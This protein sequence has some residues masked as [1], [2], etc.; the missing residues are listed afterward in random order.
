MRRIGIAGGVSLY[1][2]DD[3]YLSYFNSPFIGHRRFSS[4]DVY[5]ADGIWDGPAFSPIDGRITAIRTLKMGMKRAFPTSP[6]DYAI[7][8][9]PEGVEDSVVRILHCKPRVS[10][11]DVVSKGDVIGNMVR[12]RYFC[13]WTGPHYHV[14]AMHPKDFIRPSQS[15]PIEIDTGKIGTISG[16]STNQVECKVMKCTPD[17]VMCGSREIPSANMND[18]LGHLAMAN[19]SSGI[20]DAGIPHYKQGGLLGDMFRE[21]D[22]PVHAF[23]VSVGSVSSVSDS[24]VQFTMEKN[25]F[26]TLDGEKIGGVST[27][28]YS[29]KQLIYGRPPIFLIPEARHQFEGKISEGDCVVLSINTF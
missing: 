15:F 18:Y 21:I 19:D 12:S 29:K 7:A 16:V 13:F 3:S 27:H 1:A 4:I 11:G 8:I 2:H 23:G 20:I 17:I 14:E 25:V 9:A 28:L 6:N 10:E 26:A 5:P 24:F 22:S